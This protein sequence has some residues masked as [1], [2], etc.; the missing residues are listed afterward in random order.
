MN[1]PQPLELDYH[2]LITPKGVIAIVVR[3]PRLISPIAL[4]STG[5]T[6]AELQLLGWT[7]KPVS[8]SLIDIE[9][10]GVQK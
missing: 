9:N 5:K 10:Q 4:M 8:V 3:N 7:A 6:W 1:Q 2:A